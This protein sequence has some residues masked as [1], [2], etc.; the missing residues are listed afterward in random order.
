MSAINRALCA[1]FLN[2]NLD[3]FEDALRTDA[4]TMK[5]L[6]IVA[7]VERP[8]SAREI[9]RWK[10]KFLTPYEVSKLTDHRLCSDKFEEMVK[11]MEIAR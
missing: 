7:R 5:Q 8:L 4:P 10:T 2:E 11:R 3:V 1:R 6:E 9:E